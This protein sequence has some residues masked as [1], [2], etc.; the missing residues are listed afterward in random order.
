MGKFHDQ[1][2]EA[3]RDAMLAGTKCKEFEVVQQTD[4]PP[5][6]ADLRRLM[7]TVGTISSTRFCLAEPGQLLFVGVLH[8][9]LYVGHFW[10]YRFAYKS[11]GWNPP[12]FARLADNGPYASTDFHE[13]FPETS[14]DARES[15]RDRPPLL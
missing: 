4:D 11:A 6:L 1:I 12:E 14:E 7:E 15:W 9:P 3:I 5:G 10:A 13:L 8:R 2:R